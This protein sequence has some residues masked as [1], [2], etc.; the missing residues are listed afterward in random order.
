MTRLCSFVLG[1]LL[2]A[3]CG[4]GG[5][6][7]SGGGAPSAAQPAPPAV[8]QA[9]PPR[10]SDAGSEGSPS[11]S[12]A[13]APVGSGSGAAPLAS[14]SSAS[15]TASVSTLTFARA[16]VPA[17]FDFATTRAVR[18]VVSANEAEGGPAAYRRIQISS[19]AGAVLYR[20]RTD[21]AGQ[22]EAR[23][24]VSTSLERARVSIDAVGIASWQDVDLADELTL[25]FGPN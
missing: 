11:A 12:G 21:A 8:P 1:I 25:H 10:E 16:R 14:S 23:L 22:V 6:G 17:S 19:L 20:G 5:G 2:L 3:A 15:V 9:S 13:P 18:F 7:S 4:C 24:L